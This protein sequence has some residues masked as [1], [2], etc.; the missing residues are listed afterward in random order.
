[1]LH[2]PAGQ[3]AVITGAGGGIGS[4]IAIRASALGMRVAL[5]DTD[6]D[7]LLT[8][9]ARVSNPARAATYLV[10]VSDSDAV[11]DTADRINIELGAPSLL[12]SNAGVL[13]PRG[14]RTWEYSDEEWRHVLGVN[15]FGAIHCAR[16]FLPS[17]RTLE[18]RSHIVIVA[19]SAGVLPGRRT[20]PYFASKHALV[21][22]AEVLRAELEESA[23]DIGL[24]VV[25]P[26]GVRTRMNRN[27]RDQLPGTAA[28]GAWLEPGAVADLVLRAVIEN[29]SYAFAPTELRDRL[30]AYLGQL[31]TSFDTD[32]RM[33]SS[34]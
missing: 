10:D 17:M 6:Y 2:S 34:D 20:A 21:A 25:C 8:A 9:R 15:L 32:P 33:A 12:V 13:G 11:S 30:I 7:A 29:Q 3:V 23:A 4:E 18:A 24:S 31:L 16:A 27:L 26:G 22:L 1:M 19:S 28:D 5:L 14:K